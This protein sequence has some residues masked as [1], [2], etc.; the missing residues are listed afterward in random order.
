MSDEYAQP[1]AEEQK[2]PPSKKKKRRTGSRGDRQAQA[3]RYYQRNKAKKR[4]YMKL[5]MRNRLKQRRDQQT[6]HKI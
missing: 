1:D 3:K 2:E 5:W 4:A 6:N